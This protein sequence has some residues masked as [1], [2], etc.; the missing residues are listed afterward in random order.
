MEYQIKVVSNWLTQK[1]DQRAFWVSGGLTLILFISALIY[2]R[3]VFHVAG[4]MPASGQAVFKDHQYWRLWTAL[5]A[6]ADMGHLLGNA[7]LL[8]PL[9][10]LLSGYFGVFLF[11]ILGFLQAGLINY[12]VLKTMPSFVELLGISGL[13]NWMGAVW[14]VLF[15]LIDRRESLRKRFAVVLFVGLI[16]FAPEVYK[17]EISYISHLFGFLLGVLTALGF[18]F[19]NRQKFLDAEISEIEIIPEVKHEA[20][21]YQN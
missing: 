13:V 2:W 8:I 14:L 9:A 7:F 17:P 1:I 15:F 19:Y 4:L 11:P 18:Y 3:D 6:H 16:L 10:Y 21:L 5:F 20:E 12:F